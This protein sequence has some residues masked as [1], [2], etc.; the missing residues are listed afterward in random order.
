LTY[1]KTED[2]DR[3]REVKVVGMNKTP[4]FARDIYKKRPWKT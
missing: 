4:S 1:A 3:N 2:F